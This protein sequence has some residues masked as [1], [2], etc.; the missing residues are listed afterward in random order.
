VARRQTVAFTNI[1]IRD[2]TNFGQAFNDVP[3]KSV[4]SNWPLLV[5]LP[6]PIKH[7]CNIKTY[8]PWMQSG[9]SSKDLL[10]FFENKS[11]GPVNSLN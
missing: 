11:G 7:N 8:S 6:V 9:S 3:N 10:N 5:V 2:H 1:S 4:S